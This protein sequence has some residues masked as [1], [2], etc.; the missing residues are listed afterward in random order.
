[1][2]GAREGC[3]EPG[4]VW[5]CGGCGVAGPQ[6]SPWLCVSEQARGPVRAA[7]AAERCHRKAHGRGAARQEPERPGK[8]LPF[9]PPRGGPGGLLCSWG[10]S[11]SSS[12]PL[13]A[14]S[15]LHVGAEHRG[16]HGAGGRSMVAVEAQ[17][18]GVAVWLCACPV[19]R[20]RFFGELRG[21]SEHFPSQCTLS[22]LLCDCPALG[23]C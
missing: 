8:A 9:L 5:G 1:M 11:S 13:A 3:G 7:A 14:A 12:S 4:R 10:F 16:L 21:V 23:Q 15:L 2:R 19:A 18:G 20:A 17:R 22:C 6:L